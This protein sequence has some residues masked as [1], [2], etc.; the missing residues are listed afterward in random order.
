MLILLNNRDISILTNSI[1]AKYR[2]GLFAAFFPTQILYEKKLC[3]LV[4]RETI[5]LLSANHL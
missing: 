3:L 4:T 1:A 5:L 2:I